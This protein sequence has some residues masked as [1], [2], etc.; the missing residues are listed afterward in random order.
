MTQRDPE[1]WAAQSGVSRP[2]I[3]PRQER[4]TSPDRETQRPVFGT[5]TQFWKSKQRKRE[6]KNLRKRAHGERKPLSPYGRHRGLFLDENPVWG[7]GKNPVK[8]G[9]EKF[10]KTS[11]WRAK[12]PKPDLWHYGLG[13]LHHQR[14]SHSLETG[15]FKRGLPLFQ[16]FFPGAKISNTKNSEKSV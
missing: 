8:A 11:S 6:T 9:D 14:W 16:E 3:S 12:T 10:R 7:G 2:K 1:S 5:K 13:D 4:L 15:F